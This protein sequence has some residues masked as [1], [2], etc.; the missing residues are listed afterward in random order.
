[1]LLY[2]YVIKELLFPF[3]ASLSVIVFLFVMQQAVQLLDRIVSKGLDP[4][5]V[6]EVFVIQLGWIMALAV[7]MAILT[8]TLMT[9][10]RMSGDNE[11]TAIK[12]SGR[13]M[14][15]LLAPVF[16]SALVLTV[17]L[18]FFHDL[19]LPEANHRAANLLSD[20]SRKQP[21]AFIEPGVLI[22]DFDNYTL[23]TH[24]VD[25]ITGKM[26]GIRILTDVPGQDPSVT[27]ASNG[28]IRMTNDERY[29]ELTLLDGETHSYPKN[30][31]D[32]YYIGRFERQV[33]YIE[34]ID[35][36]LTRTSSEYRSDREKNI[37]MMLTDIAHL[38]KSNSTAKTEYHLII[39]SL[40]G[41]IKYLDSLA[42]A[43]HPQND[44]VEDFAHWAKDLPKGNALKNSLK[45]QQNVVE[46]TTRRIHSNNLM[47]AQYM[48][49]V[50]KK[51]AIPVAC[52][53]FV[54]I[55]APLGIMARK[56]GLAVG[57]S[58]SVFFFIAYWAFLIT[59]ESMADKLIV[60]PFIGMWA[61]NIIIGI[62]GTILTI[63]MLRETSIRFDFV[64]NLFSSSDLKGS[65]VLNKLTGLYMFKIPGLLFRFPRTVMKWSMGTLPAYLSGMFLRF[66]AGLLVAILI[67]FVVVDYIGNLR[68]FEH[69]SV[70]EAGLYYLYYMPWIIQTILPVV[71]L[72]ATMFSIGQMAK[73]SEITALK[74]SGMSVRRLSVPLLAAGL[75]FSAAAFYGG[76]YLLPQANQLR[77]ELSSLMRTPPQQRQ[78]VGQRRE[79]RRSFYYFGNPNTMYYFDE[80]SVNPQFARGVQRQ[81]FRY[82]G[83]AERITAQKMLF[84]DHEGWIF[85]NGQQRNF[86]S[87]GSTLVTFD[88]LNDTILSSTPSDMVKRVRSERELSY[89]ELRSY[90]DMARRRGEQ[91][92]RLVAE[93]EF[94]IALPLMNFVVI[95]LGL[96]IT[97]RTGRKGG[98]VLFGIG[99]GLTFMY[100][101]IARFAISFAQNGHLSPM[102]GA[103]SGN[104][105]F[106]L[107]GLYL[108]RKAAH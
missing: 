48:V 25:P 24:E 26:S 55:G 82:D 68:R 87:D 65:R 81:T 32:E 38:E 12:A 45:R 2:R 74:A 49:E 50:H 104:L 101:L 78:N 41:Q 94:K 67:I 35:S 3:F 86:S 93:M 97:A 106:F 37:S 29:L 60:T 77:S 10:G 61:G 96:G 30:Q 28:S 53:L 95:L 90:I 42:T 79:F 102:V 16:V 27:V 19:V 63:L 20:I 85:E 80:F 46:R 8:A 62:C 1:M 11:V 98:P 34:N 4:V 17:A 57:A 105:L 92:H 54:L 39:D 91:V 22:R 7:P 43:F 14:L 18:I 64:K 76:E 88:R 15:S 40:S 21:A 70:T 51:F 59:G 73:H 44:T 71:L 5:I 99:L 103:W 58:Y 9:F 56:G 107:I 33:V 66:T 31:T 36:R 6:V 108:Y 100:Y 52:L 89:W 72:L 23:Y 47:I 83:M 69:A 84:D 13:S 75:L